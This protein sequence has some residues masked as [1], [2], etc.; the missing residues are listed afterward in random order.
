MS[1]QA[2]AW[3]N[4]ARGARHQEREEAKQLAVQFMT[5]EKLSAHRYLR[6]EYWEK[7]VLPFRE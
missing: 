2:Y 5:R 7:Y 6:A 3:L 4:I 1:V